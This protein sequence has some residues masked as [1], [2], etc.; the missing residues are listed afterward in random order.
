MFLRLSVILFT[1]G[2]SLSRK[3]L[4]PGG[5]SVQGGL[6]QGD[7]PH[8]VTC[9]RYASYWNA[10]FMF[11]IAIRKPVDDNCNYKWLQPSIV[12]QF[13]LDLIVQMSRVKHILRPE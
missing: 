6:C 1:V 10:F 13:N 5:G 7:P 12:S 2:G 3:G 11:L 8:T 9:G 4:C